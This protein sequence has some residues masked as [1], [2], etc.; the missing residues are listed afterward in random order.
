MDK[1]LSLVIADDHP[2]FLRGLEGILEKHKWISIAARPQDGE[3]ALEAIRTLKP[4]IAIVDLYMP[5]MDGVKVVTAVK[6]EQLPAKMIILTMHNDEHLVRSLFALGLQGYILKENAIA[7]II[8][9]IEVVAAGRVFYSPQAASYLL[10][11]SESAGADKAK[12]TPTEMKIL[13]LIGQEKS[14]QQIARELFLSD[15][16][17]RNHRANICKKLGISGNFAL[18]RYALKMKEN[19]GS[20]L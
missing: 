14:S 2:V 3:A 12:L 9:C 4:D 16:T 15:N 18:V 6:Q 17:I 8:Q 19:K 11:K 10:N 5:R 7:E 20:L 1:H 13:E